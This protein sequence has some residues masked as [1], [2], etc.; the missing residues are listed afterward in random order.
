MSKYL[1]VDLDEVIRMEEG[2]KAPRSFR[3]RGRQNFGGTTNRPN[4]NFSNS[5][6]IIKKNITKNFPQNR[7]IFNNRVNKDKKAKLPEE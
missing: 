7:P 6:R 1:N 3:H 5:G 2:N 4:N